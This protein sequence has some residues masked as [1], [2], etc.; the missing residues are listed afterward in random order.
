MLLGSDG[1]FDAMTTEALTETIWECAY[2]LQ[3]EIT[4]NN[5]P[6]KSAAKTNPVISI[7]PVIQTRLNFSNDDQKPKANKLVS[8]SFKRSVNIK[9]DQQQ[10]YAHEKPLLHKLEQFTKFSSNQKETPNLGSKIQK[11]VSTAEPRETNKNF[12]KDNS[13]MINSK[14]REVSSKHRI[15][16]EEKP[17]LLSSG[18]IALMNK[19]RTLE[20]LNQDKKTKQQPDADNFDNSKEI[21][22]KILPEVKFGQQNETEN[23][24]KLIILPYVFTP[25]QLSE[26]ILKKVRDKNLSTLGC[27]DNLS[28]VVVFLHR[29]LKK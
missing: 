11:K 4:K 25:Q 29:G 1:I 10:L 2:N 7:N 20:D 19:P 26:E 9:T 23:L 16:I 12:V 24:R 28:L 15:Q 14:A 8:N 22:N 3:A 6:V 21:L 27:S 17:N 13:R 5:P 18:Q